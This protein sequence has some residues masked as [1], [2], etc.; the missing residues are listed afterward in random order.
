MSLKGRRSRIAL[1][2]VA[3]IAAALLFS[4]CV[5]DLTHD[6]SPR[7]PDCAQLISLVEATRD[8]YLTGDASYAD[9]DL[10]SAPSLYLTSWMARLLKATGGSLTH[11]QSEAM[12]AFLADTLRQLDEGMRHGDLQEADS[13]DPLSQLSVTSLVIGAIEGVSPS[14]RSRA[15]TVIASLGTKGGYAWDKG[16]ESSLGATSAAVSVLAQL[17]A[18]IPQ[19]VRRVVAARSRKHDWSAPTPWNTLVQVELPLAQLVALAGSARDI[20][21]FK[22]A[23]TVIEPL[24]RRTLQASAS[25]AYGV[26]AA[27]Q[28]RDVAKDFGLTFSVDMEAP[29]EALR[30]RAGFIPLSPSGRADPQVT[31][32][33]LQL[34]AALE[35]MLLREQALRTFIRNGWRRPT[36]APNPTVALR[37]VALYRVCALP[38]PSFP[39]ANLSSTSGGDEDEISTCMLRQ[40]YGES[41]TVHDVQSPERCTRSPSRDGAT[42]ASGTILDIAQSIASGAATSETLLR[43]RRSDGL[44]SAKPTSPPDIVSTS[45][46][47]LGTDCAASATCR[48]HAGQAFRDGDVPRALTSSKEGSESSTVLLAYALIRYGTWNDLS[49][50]VPL[51]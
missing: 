19:E 39:S 20:E 42:A 3:L 34:G 29:I 22:G 27:S 44:F 40:L 30:T 17:G 36:L 11:T 1:L 47:V 16:G 50:L 51:R 31:L 8:P 13:S 10:S 15:L 9:I 18:P 21:R 46:G 45:I 6:S 12:D 25:S 5:G 41:S 35:P 14:V 33:A 4:G 37:V 23:W 24:W 48:E 32:A 49:F 28:A 7:R 38:L 2:P 26:L 43:F